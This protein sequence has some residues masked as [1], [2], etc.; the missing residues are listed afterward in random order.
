[1]S[2]EPAQSSGNTNHSQGAGE[3]DV[4]ATATKALAATSQPDAPATGL[5]TAQLADAADALRWLTAP[6]DTGAGEQVHQR[7]MSRLARL[8][9]D[10]FIPAEL[11]AAIVDDPDGVPR[12]NISINMPLPEGRDILE[13]EMLA[14]LVAQGVPT[15]SRPYDD[16]LVY[17]H[18]QVR[19]VF[20]AAVVVSPYSD[21]ASPARLWQLLGGE[22]PPEAKFVMSFQIHSR[23]RDAAS[24]QPIISFKNVLPAKKGRGIASRAFDNWVRVMSTLFPGAPVHTT[25]SDLK[26]IIMFARELIFHHILPESTHRA[27]LFQKKIAPL[28]AFLKA[29]NPASNPLQWFDQLAAMAADVARANGTLVLQPLW[30]LLEKMS[31][32]PGIVTTSSYLPGEISMVARLPA[33]TI[34]LECTT[35]AIVGT[36]AS[37]TMHRGKVNALNAQLIAE[38]ACLF[39]LAERRSEVTTIILHGS[40]GKFGAGVDLKEETQH[41]QDARLDNNLDLMDRIMA[42]QRAFSRSQK[43]VVCEIGKYAI[44]GSLQ[45]ALSA[46]KVV[47]HSQARL[48]F[49]EGLVGVIP[50]FIGG[51]QL[52]QHLLTKGVDQHLL[53]YLQASGFQLSGAEAYHLGLVDELLDSEPVAKEIPEIWRE[54]IAQ[55]QDPERWHETGLSIAGIERIRRMNLLSAEGYL[56]AFETTFMAPFVLRTLRSRLTDPTSKSQPVNER[57][58][59]EWR[60]LLFHD[61]GILAEHIQP[62]GATLEILLGTGFVPDAE[63][64]AKLAENLNALDS[65]GELDRLA[66]LQFFVD[67]NLHTHHV[68]RTEHAGA[69][70][71]VDTVANVV[72]RANANTLQRRIYERHHRIAHGPLFRSVE[73]HAQQTIAA[74]EYI[75]P[76]AKFGPAVLINEEALVQ[77]D[78]I[79]AN[80]SESPAEATSVGEEPAMAA[81][82]LGPEGQG[83]GSHASL[84]QQIRAP[85]LR[86]PVASILFAR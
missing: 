48:A 79:R 30:F 5:T 47:A 19:D 82:L 36:T 75:L 73:V 77:D 84:L 9:P 11:L 83:A 72:A 2:T 25:F 60:S 74:P 33:A 42:L 78:P 46:K 49:P 3:P 53:L 45:L 62:L 76:A 59:A 7:N 56:D 31:A 39:A 40:H 67:G 71:V 44:A 14:Q 81:G 29:T 63:K 68:G 61:W 80:T 18:Y 66:R 57:S 65:T 23:E 21:L 26:A 32:R 8:S 52:I 15:T 10:V 64:L 86:P 51:A 50:G 27:L 69:F 13:A 55:M 24:N 35:L 6:E 38:I 4:G 22:R 54:R 70:L 17:L 58:S 16:C 37:I 20:H 41:L 34:A 43:Q 28:D 85:A 1:M 12:F